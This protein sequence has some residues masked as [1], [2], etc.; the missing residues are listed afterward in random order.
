MRKKNF[1]GEKGKAFIEAAQKER[2]VKYSDL[3][4]Q[5]KL[6]FKALPRPPNWRDPRNPNDDNDNDNRNKIQ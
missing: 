2:E 6:D 4:D 3:Y 1:A 5:D